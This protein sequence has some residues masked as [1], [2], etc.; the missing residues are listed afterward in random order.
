MTYEDAAKEI[1]RLY[2][3]GKVV[4]AAEYIKAIVKEAVHANA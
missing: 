2:Q 4:E 1:H 3:D